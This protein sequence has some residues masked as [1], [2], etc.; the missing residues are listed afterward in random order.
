MSE[1]FIT[2]TTSLGLIALAEMGDK[3]QLVCMT[4][5]ARHR[6]LPVWL[7]AVSAFIVLNLLAVAFGATT[8]RWLPEWLVSAAVAILFA[9]FAYRSLR[10]ADDNEETVEERNGRS[11]FLSTALLIFVAEFGDKTQLAVAGLAGTYQA[12]PVW[13][14]ATLGLTLATT[15]GVVAGK[16][17]LQR[18]PEKLLHYLSAVFFLLLA[19]LAAWHT[20]ATF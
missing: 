15:L 12:L 20:L 10:A 6:A 19:L 1:F 9:L 13:V 16:T 14:G 8:A 11:V 18:L 17:V 5:A 2:M 3:T 4:L 7:G